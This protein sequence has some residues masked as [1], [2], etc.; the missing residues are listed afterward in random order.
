MRGA[1]GSVGMLKV[2][3]IKGEREKKILRSIYSI[4]KVEERRKGIMT[5]VAPDTFGSRPERPINGRGVVTLRL[6]ENLFAMR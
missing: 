2:T 6:K 5:E 4:I 3:Q 1:T